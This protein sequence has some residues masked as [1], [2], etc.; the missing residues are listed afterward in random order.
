MPKQS[1]V[2]WSPHQ[3]CQLY[4][5]IQKGHASARTIRRAYTRLLADEQP[6]AATIAAMLHPSA[7]TVTLMCQQDLTAGL[8]AAW[9]DRPRP[10]ARRTLDGRQAAHLSALACSAPPIGRER[11]RVR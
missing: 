2:Q 3:C 9:Y 11:W 8:E 7:V 6:P 5:L 10:G 1:V 4:A